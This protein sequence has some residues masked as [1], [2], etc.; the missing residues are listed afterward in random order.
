MANRYLKIEAE[1][2]RINLKK[3]SGQLLHIIEESSIKMLNFYSL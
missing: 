2:F 3:L 1:T